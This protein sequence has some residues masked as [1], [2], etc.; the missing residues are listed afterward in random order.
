[1]TKEEFLDLVNDDFKDP[2]DKDR[3]FLGMFKVIL[4]MKITTDVM[5]KHL[6]RKAREVRRINRSW[7]V[8]YL[9]RRTKFAVL[10]TTNRKKGEIISQRLDAV[11]NHSGWHP[12]LDGY[13]VIMGFENCYEQCE[14]HWGHG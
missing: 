4:G 3:M 8:K 5:I 13:Y 14:A 1:M 11:H 9:E 6:E 10:L 2:N 7:W 12:S